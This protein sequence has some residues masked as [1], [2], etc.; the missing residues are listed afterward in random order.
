MNPVIGF[1]LGLVVTMG[2]VFLVLLYLRNPLQVILNDL[3]GTNERA[4]FW[5]AF[6]N[7]VVF[8]ERSFSIGPGSSAGGWRN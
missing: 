4:R 3:C 1:V 5:T 2:V 7:T 6:S 8:P